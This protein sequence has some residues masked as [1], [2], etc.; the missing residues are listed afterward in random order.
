[1]SGNKVPH[2]YKNNLK[3]WIK[4]RG[5]KL[6]QVAGEVGIGIRTLND[7]CAGRVPTPRDILERI[8]QFIGCPV[9]YLENVNASSEAVL[10]SDENK[11]V[12]GPV[13]WIDL[14]ESRQDEAPSLLVNQGDVI[15]LTGEEARLFLSRLGEDDMARFDPERR[16][17]LLK[18]L[19]AVETVSGTAVVIPHILVNLEPWERLIAATS[20]P[21]AL[22]NETLST[23]TS[24]TQACWKLTNSGELIIA[25]MT[26][27]S[28]LPTLKQVAPSQPQV[29]LLTSQALQLRSVL[30][31][32]QLKIAEKLALCQQAVEYARL[33]QDHNTLVAELTEL[34]VAYVYNNQY[35]KALTSYQEALTYCGYDD[36]SPLLRSRTYVEAGAIFAHYKRRKEADF[37]LDMAYEAFP[38]DPVSDPAHLYADHSRGGLALYN[39]LIQL[40]KGDAIQAW[41]G[42]ESFKDY[43]FA[44]PERIRVLIVNQQGRAALLGNDLEK[45]A[46]CLEEGIA[47]AVALKSKKRFA[48]AYTIFQQEMPKDWLQH[49][50]IKPI[51]ER[52]QLLRD[53]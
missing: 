39:G 12:A 52:Y 4:Q 50:K 20:Q 53:N 27:A 21:S 33:A 11:T 41:N 22:N 35:D 6:Y 46:Y 34:A 19:Q 38:T 23:F 51:V 2:K 8:A 26:L 40:E 15:V 30:V 47:G 1:M 24:L 36:V 9:S 48:E 29:A 28:F 42:F 3:L 16:S 17:S 10:A 45:Y 32:H 49:H 13:H 43:D 5:Y 14:I 31:S 18:A 7:Y 37:Y 44:L 25:E